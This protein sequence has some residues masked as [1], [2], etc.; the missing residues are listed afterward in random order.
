LKN[1]TM[2]ADEDWRYS[3]LVNL[4]MNTKVDKLSSVDKE[5]HIVI[6]SGRVTYGVKDSRG[7]S[8]Y[9]YIDLIKNLIQRHIHVHLH[10]KFIIENSDNK[11]CYINNPYFLIAKESEYFHIDNSLDLENDIANSYSILKRYDAG[12]MHNYVEGEEINKFTKMNVP[13]RLF[14]YQM[15]SVLP[16]VFKGTMLDVEDIIKETDF[17][18]IVKDYDELK[19]ILYENIKNNVE[20]NIRTSVKT[21]SDFVSILFKAING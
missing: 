8:R 5:P 17:G 18:I 21:Y 1:K 6:L 11:V 16:V 10:T 13:N 3:G 20:I 15:A 4:I 7:N 9:N 19:Q 2:F 12:I 14:E